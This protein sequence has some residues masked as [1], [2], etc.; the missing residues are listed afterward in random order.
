MCLR[1]GLE[2]ALEQ[3]F[4]KKDLMSLTEALKGGGQTV[5]LV[6]TKPVFGIGPSEL[7]R[8]HLIYQSLHIS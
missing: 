4:D 5:D 7:S 8:S 3:K 6:C 2:A 1:D